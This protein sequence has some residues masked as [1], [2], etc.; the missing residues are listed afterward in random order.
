MSD[1]LFVML[2]GVAGSGKSTY[3]KERQ[4]EIDRCIVLSS[5]AIRGE[6]YGD[7]SIQRNPAKVFQIMERRALDAARMGMS[8]I[9]D[10]TNLSSRRRKHMVKQMSA[11]G[12]TTECVI[13]VASRDLCVERQTMRERKVPADVIDRQIRQFEVPTKM[14]GWDKIT[15]SY[16]NEDSYVKSLRQ[17]LD[18]CKIPHDNPHH[19]MS[20]YGHSC[21]VHNTVSK[22]IRE[23][24]YASN[25][26]ERYLDYVVIKAALFHDA[27]KPFTKTFVNGRGETTDIA[28]YYGHENVGAW[29]ILCAKDS[30]VMLEDCLR[31]AQLI[32]LHMKMHDKVWHERLKEYWVEEDLNFWNQLYLLWEADKGAH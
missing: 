16:P 2:V 27:G 6:L 8:V 28:H 11:L 18:D 25:V 23:K 3:A 4:K 13:C 26:L 17:L 30:F 12:C 24:Y 9:Y 31:C 21:A 22:K 32:G 19:T 1:P 7:E 5:D 20:I 29:L 14:E 10:A 15:V